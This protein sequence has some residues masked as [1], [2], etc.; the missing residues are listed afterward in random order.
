MS[1]LAPIDPIMFGLMYSY[2]WFCGFHLDQFVYFSL[3]SFVLCVSLVYAMGIV[4]LTN[5][6][7][8]Y[9]IIFL[10]VL[11]LLIEDSTTVISSLQIFLRN[12]ISEA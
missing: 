8:K 10:Y 7:I 3:L 4:F 6:V 1:F 11:V 5:S 12:Y 9:K 2:C